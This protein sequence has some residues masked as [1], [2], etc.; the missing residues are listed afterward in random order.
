ME[1]LD[2][3]QTI[4]GLTAGQK[5]FR[6]FT[7]VRILGRG[8][9]GVVWLARD[10]ELE[11]DVALKFLPYLVV[12]DLAVLDELKRETR[13]SL[14]LTHHHIVRTHDFLQDAESACISMEYV[15]GPTLSA[16]RVEQANRV[17]EADELLP[18]AEQICEALHYAHEHAR[19]VHRDIKP[20][21]LML[22]SRGE[23]KVADFGIA[24]SLSDSVTMLT[25]ARGTSGTLA[26]MSPQQLD[27]E[28]A[29]NLDDIYSL[30]A[31]LY[32]LL[33]SKPPFHSGLIERM[34]RE[35]RPVSLAAKREELGVSSNHRIPEQWEQTIAACLAK[36][37]GAR[38]RNALEVRD[39]LRAPPTPWP[40]APPP[41][42]TPPPPPPPPSPSLPPPARTPELSPFPKPSPYLTKRVLIIGAAIVLAALLAI[43]IGTAIWWFSSR[44]E[45]PVAPAPV[46][47]AVRPVAVPV[48]TP[49]PPAVTPSPV[50]QSP[51]PSETIKP[52]PT[53]EAS[54]SVTSALSEREQIEAMVATQIDAGT[55]GDVDASMSL[56]ADSVD[57]LD[58]GWKSRDAIAKDLP[59]YFAHWPVRRS[60]LLG[61]VAIE[62]VTPNERKVSYVLDFEASNPT[63]REV[64]QSRVNVVWTIRRDASWLPFKIVSH[65]QTRVPQEKAAESTE[66]DPAIAVV[67]DYFTAV[68]NQDG[69]AAYR[70]FGATYR[71]RVPFQDYLRRLKN[72][73]TLTLNSIRR[74]AA[75]NSSATVEITFQEVETNG[76][77][78]RWHGPVSLVV[79]NGEWR[80]DTLKNLQSVR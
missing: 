72:T 48:V 9:M 14:Q 31:T 10:D 50:I 18:W 38:P 62:F 49:T 21:N 23:L 8:G 42:V 57:F 46:L 80:I 19:I 52:T 68:N 2:L 27:G 59:E 61:D 71:K 40:I 79:E 5:V 67:K 47:P 13:R 56:Y 43:V 29:S 69:T 39:R 32:E 36:D 6:R 64:R 35:K 11:R 74:T 58:E 16:L 25:M 66:A 45:S 33:A 65:K 53:P 77:L 75:T 60:K 26:Y 44:E 12:H 41:V 3:G 22:N 78:I 73:G 51:T 4:R 28:R 7:L 63:T 24:R 15:D 20:A 37:Q 34:I 70:L 54:P 30:G 17:F 76:K 55:R 1:E